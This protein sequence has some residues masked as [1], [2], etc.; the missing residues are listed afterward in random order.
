MRSAGG[1][2]RLLSS[3][4]MGARPGRIPVTAHHPKARDKRA[5]GFFAAHGQGLA[6]SG[7][8][9]MNRRYI[10]MVIEIIIIKVKKLTI[11]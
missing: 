9:E 8:C 11:G 4:M 2:V 10:I 5:F 1:G 7:A 3:V 6:G